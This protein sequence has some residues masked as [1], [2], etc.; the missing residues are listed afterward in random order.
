MLLPAQRFC[1]DSM[2]VMKSK[3]T[4]SKFQP[5]LAI[6][7]HVCTTSS[8]RLL[9]TLAS[10]PFWHRLFRQ[11]YRDCCMISQFQQTR[12]TGDNY[13]RFDGHA[14]QKRASD[15]LTQ[16]PRTQRITKQNFLSPIGADRSRTLEF[17]RTTI[18]I[19][20][21]KAP[22]MAPTIDFNGLHEANSQLITLAGS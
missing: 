18:L 17:Q 16:Q 5:S 6:Q 14:I 11:R 21:Q 2:R 7:G 22:D 4:S 12:I 13:A 3:D 8:I 19:G 20:N 9:R 15:Q 1:I 10:A